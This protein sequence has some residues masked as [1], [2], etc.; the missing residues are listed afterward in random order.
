MITITGKDFYRCKHCRKLYQIKRA[1]EMHEKRCKKNPDNWRACNGCK[2]AVERLA[3]LEGKTM[4][5][6]K[7]TYD[8]S[9]LYCLKKETFIHP[10][11]IEHK[12]TAAIIIGNDNIP[13]PRTCALRQVDEPIEFE[14]VDFE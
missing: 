3:N 1:A 9:L 7:F 12:G 10:P 14:P 8:K 6:E 4:N 5:G 11:I 13:M 2:F